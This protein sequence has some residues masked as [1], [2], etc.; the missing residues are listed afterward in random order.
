V[1]TFR[2]TVAFTFMVL[3]IISFAH[4][5]RLDGYFGMGTT[6]VGASPYPF[7]DNNTGESVP[8]PHMGG[9]FGTFGGAIMLK[10]HFGF[11]GQVSLRFA[12][13]D[14][15]GFGYR[16]IF[17][18][19]N[20]I[21]TPQIYKIE[22][23]IVPEFQGGLGGLNLRFYDPS[24][25]YY[26]YNSGRYTNFAGSSNHFQL[27]AAAGLRF[28]LKPRVWVRPMVDYHWVRNLDRNEFGSNN[29]FSYSIAIGFS[30]SEY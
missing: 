24:T 4:A 22:K 28:K 26:D 30:S 9:V 14:F 23:V 15:A 7:V 29:V 12:Q 3:F 20:G 18:D 6:Q 19:F 5:Q 2:L 27:H 17:Y 1:K 8:A 13:G 25:Y 11:G 10:P 21:W 16:P